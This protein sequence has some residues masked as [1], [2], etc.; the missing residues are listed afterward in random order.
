M[1]LLLYKSSFRPHFDYND[2]IYDQPNNF[3]LS[4]KVEAVQY[5]ATLAI[6]GAIKRTSKEK[7]HLGLGHKPLKNRRWLRRLSHLYKIILTNLPPYL[8]ELIPPLQR[9]HWYLRCFQT[10]C[11]RTTVSQIL[12]LPFTITEWNKLDSHIKNIDS[13][14]LTFIRSLKTDTFEIWF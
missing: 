2:V 9:S 6:T 11:C 5:N 3:R 7:L 8:Y 1:N 10:L 14:R 4:D 12:F 13:Q